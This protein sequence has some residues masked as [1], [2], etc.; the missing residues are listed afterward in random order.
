MLIVKAL[1]QILI[2]KRAQ[3]ALERS[4]ETDDFL[5]FLFSIALCTTGDTCDV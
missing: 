1:L 2:N 4:P 3:R 5:E